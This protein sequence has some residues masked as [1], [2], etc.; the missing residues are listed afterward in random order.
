MS[1]LPEVHNFD[2][3]EVHVDV[4]LL[5]EGEQIKQHQH[6]YPHVMFI[7]KGEV[8][9]DIGGEVKRHVAPIEIQLVAGVSHG[10]TAITDAVVVNA[11]PTSENQWSPSAS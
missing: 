10:A 3:Y 6:E 2:A 7:A 8:D 11:F 5:K 9:V 4:F 1:D